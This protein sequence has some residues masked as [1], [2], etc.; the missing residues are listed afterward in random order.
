MIEDVRGRYKS[1]GVF[2]PLRQEVADGEDTLSWIAHQEWSNRRVGMTG[3][4]YLG[5]AQWKAA[6]SGSPYL[7][8]IFPIVAGCDEYFD[9][10]YSRGGRSSS[11]TV[12][13]GSRRTSAA[14][15]FQPDF[16]RFV[17]ETPLRQ[18][19]P[20]G[21]G[22]QRRFLPAGA[23]PPGLRRL[24]EVGQHSRATRPGPRSGL[25]RGRMV[26]QFRRERPGGFRHPAPRRPRLPDLGRAV[27]PRPLLPFRE[28]QLRAGFEGAAARDAA[29]LVRHVATDTRRGPRP[30]GARCGSGYR[31]ALEDLRHGR[32]PLAR[33]AG[34]APRSR[35]GDAVL[36][37]WPGQGRHAG[38]RR[39]SGAAEAAPWSAATG[40]HTI[41][42]IPC[43]PRAATC[44]A[45]PCG[46]PGGL[47]TSARSS[48]AATSSSTPARLSNGRSR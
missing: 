23:G 37:G 44:A 46:C 16:D 40:S 48:G 4:S 24:L 39:A 29:R 26:R 7:K 35:G 45:I 41:P 1:E 19:G 3:A 43:R 8:A 17:A 15:A 30:R 20:S 2:D 47:G 32:Q 38:R 33:R 14:P 34:V 13:S 12:W 18:R 25:R 10:F 36:P 22:P 28:R 21:H 5:I 9:R 42:P 6:L 31:G 11:A 27:A